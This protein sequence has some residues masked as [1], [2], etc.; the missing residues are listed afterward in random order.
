ME[1]LRLIRERLVIKFK[2]DDIKPE[3][4]SKYKVFFLIAYKVAKSSLINLALEL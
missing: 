3:T 4:Y 2:V 1:L